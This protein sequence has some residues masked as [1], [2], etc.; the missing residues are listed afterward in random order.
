MLN[1]KT[2]TVGAKVK[3]VVNYGSHKI[4]TVNEVIAIGKVVEFKV[5]E[6]LLNENCPAGREKYAVVGATAAC[7]TAYF[8]KFVAEGRYS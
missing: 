6:V 4:V 2:L 1:L 7:V 5:V 3:S 8:D